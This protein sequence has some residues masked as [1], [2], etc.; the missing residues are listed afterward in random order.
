MT[1][2]LY[3]RVQEEGLDALKEYIEEGLGYEMF[4]VGFPPFVFTKIRVEDRWGGWYWSL[5]H[6]RATEKGLIE[7]L[8]VV[9]H[10]EW[11][12]EVEMDDRD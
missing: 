11:M 9:P 8:S 1:E 12:K 10:P 6:K 5:T 2:T 3:D 4:R 7:A